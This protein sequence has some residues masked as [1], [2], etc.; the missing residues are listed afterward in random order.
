MED[1]HD[2]NSEH[3]C[4]TSPPF[5]VLFRFGKIADF[6]HI[7]HTNICIPFP[8]NKRRMII[9]IFIKMGKQKQ[10]YF[11][12]GDIF[13]FAY[14]GMKAEPNRTVERYERN[15]LRLQRQATRKA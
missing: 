9:I 15:A 7:T 12:L 8:V 2:I 4:I 14:I 13:F 11:T 6:S 10:H 5:P 3:M 1:D